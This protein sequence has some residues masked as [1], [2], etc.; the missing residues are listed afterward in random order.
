[1]VV[2]C[3][4]LCG[5]ATDYALRAI[6]RLKQDSSTTETKSVEESEKRKA[7]NLNAVAV[8][9]CCHHRCEWSSFVGREWLISHGMQQHEFAVMCKWASWAV[10]VP[11]GMDYKATSDSKTLKSPRKKIKRTKIP[12]SNSNADDSISVRSRVNFYNWSPEERLQI[13]LKCKRVLDGA[14]EDFIRTKT[15]LRT[16]LVRYVGPEVTTENRL[17]LAF[18]R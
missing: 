14:R 11:H 7:T 18:P 9:T 8:A 5:K 4:H 6:S 15:G 1:M 16:K 3:K 12:T 17:L 2:G 13:G 10:S